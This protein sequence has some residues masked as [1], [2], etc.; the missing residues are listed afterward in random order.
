MRLLVTSQYDA[1]KNIFLSRSKLH[2]LRVSNLQYQL[3]AAPRAIFELR[4]NG[5]R[6]YLVSNET[7]VSTSAHGVYLYI[8][9]ATDP[10]RIWCGATDKTA[11]SN[12]KPH[13]SIIGHTSLSKR[14]DV[15]FAGELHFSKGHLISWSNES[16]HYRPP[17]QL[18]YSN[19]LPV[20]RLLLPND[21]FI[22]Y[23]CMTPSEKIKW[24]ET[25]GY[26]IM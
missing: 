8:I 2:P 4:K 24:H 18:R 25:R 26:E 1:I 21:L 19:L 10:G 15:L 17:A 20:V 5:P 11:I 16:G 12:L 13:L 9:L 3:P 14:H 22:D 23:W 7:G 6:Y